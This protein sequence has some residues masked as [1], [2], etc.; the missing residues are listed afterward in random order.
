MCCASKC[1]D[2]VER[3]RMTVSLTNCFLT[4]PVH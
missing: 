4:L 2:E 3:K 1:M